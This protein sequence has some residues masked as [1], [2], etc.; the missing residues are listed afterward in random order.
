MPAPSTTTPGFD[1]GALIR[2]A[3]EA[4]EAAYAP[5]SGFR[6]GA[7]LLSKSGKVFVG[8][9]VENISFGLTICAERAAV[10]AAIAA[11]EREFVS[12]AVVAD[13]SPP[14]TPCGA[15]RQVL[16]EFA[17][18]LPIC[19]ANLAGDTYERSLAELLPRPT[20][21]IVPRRCST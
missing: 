20:E 17:P 16:A 2:S 14:V 7:A 5:F 4:R 11:G 18:A 10:C 21:G 9:N 15:C 19:S 3:R 6:V 1:F 12:L 8:C 13:S